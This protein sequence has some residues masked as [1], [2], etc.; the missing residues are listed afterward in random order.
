MISQWRTKDNS[1]ESDNLEF[2]GLSTDQKPTTWNG[3]DIGNGSAFFEIDT[4]SVKF[5]NAATKSWV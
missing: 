1:T 5:F 4:Q 2:R 3:K